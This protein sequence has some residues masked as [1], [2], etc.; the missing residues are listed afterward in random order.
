MK[1]LANRQLNAS[2]SNERKETETL[3]GQTVHWIGAQFCVCYSE[4]ATLCLP[5][6]TLARNER[7]F[8]LSILES[9]SKIR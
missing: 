1:K 5:D 2:Q 6:K 4:L 8:L 3:R 7:S 9:K